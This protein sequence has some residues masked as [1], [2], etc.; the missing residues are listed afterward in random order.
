MPYFKARQIFITCREICS[1]YNGFQWENVNE[2]ASNQ[3][4]ADTRL[5]LHSHHASRNGF[6]DIMTHIPDTDVFLLMFSMSNETAG[7]LCMK[8]G[9]RGKT[10]MINIADVR[11]NQMEKYQNRILI[12]CWQRYLPCMHSPVA[13]QL[14]PSLEKGKSKPSC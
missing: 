6:D 8:T 5:L 11:I 14:V 1:Y 2:L 13:I 4:E 7:K 12:M 9:T 10:R 3:E